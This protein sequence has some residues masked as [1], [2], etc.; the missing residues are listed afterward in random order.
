MSSQFTKYTSTDASA[1]SLTGA[2]GSLLGVLD[3]C[4]VNGYGSQAAAGWT[5]PTAN[6]G[7][8]GAYTQGQGSGFVL[9]IN[10]NG[11]N[12][13][14]TYKEAWGIGWK[15]LVGIGSP[16]GSGTGQFP[17]PTQLLTTGHVVIRKSTT[18]DAT[19]RPWIVYAD[20]RTFYL[21]ILTGDNASNY[22]D[23]GFGDFYSL[24]GGTD[25]NNCFICG[26][27]TENSGT[28]NNTSMGCLDRLV[29]PANTGQA[30]F[31]IADTLAGGS[32]SI[33]GWT[34]GDGSKL[35]GFTSTSAYLVAGS[36]PA[37]NPTDGA[38]YLSPQWVL[39]SSWNVRGYMR[40]LYQ[41]CHPVASFADGA[42]F[43]GANDLAGKTFAVTMLG[44]NGGMYCVETSATVDTN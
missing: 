3:A 10:D 15:T 6:S 30:G 39:E 33:K 26:R 25:V 2:A 13:S 35:T 28:V 9:V 37:P 24:N 36:L 1:P 29:S 22:F 31:Y 5:K 11:P 42:T 21:F 16:V 44:V 38:Y 20:Q 14:S 4:L 27:N 18:A 19:A 12:G 41:L 17:T 43:S 40:G 23:F 7:N 8:I 34:L 32:G